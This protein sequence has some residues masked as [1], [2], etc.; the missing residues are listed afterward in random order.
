MLIFG[1]GYHQQQQ[2]K[3]L[4]LNSLHICPLESKP[5]DMENNLGKRRISSCICYGSRHILVLVRQK[6]VTVIRNKFSGSSISFSHLQQTLTP[7]IRK[8]TPFYGNQY[9]IPWQ[10]YH[11]TCEQ[12]CFTFILKQ[13]CCPFCVLFP[14][15]TDIISINSRLWVKS[16]SY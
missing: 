11:S 15:T 13:G 3:Y 6:R 4:V 7:D 5:L 12:Y 10:K 1:K 8:V 9:L 14:L 2:A 16:L